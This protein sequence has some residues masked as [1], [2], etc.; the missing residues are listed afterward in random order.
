MSR[1]PFPDL[2]KIQHDIS[3]FEIS[4]LISI[5]TPVYNPDHRYLHECLE[6]VLS[7]SYSNWQLCLIDDCSTDTMYRKFYINIKRVILGFKCITAR[8]MAISRWPV[9]MVWQWLKGEFVALLDHDD[10]LHEHA[11]YAVVK[12]LQ[13]TPDA[14]HLQR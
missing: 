6:S 13:L 12:Q 8:K 9:M 2:A 5:V 3:H 11:L 1:M 4:P 10:K 14:R 7:Q